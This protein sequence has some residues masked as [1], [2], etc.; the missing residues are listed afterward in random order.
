[1][2]R[3]VFHLCLA[4]V[5]ML[6]LLPLSAA[7]TTEQRWKRAID[8]DD[9][10][11]I[12]QM[13]SGTD[14]TLTNDK[15]KT[16]LMTA[17]KLGDQQLLQIL[18]DKGLTLEDRSFT[19]GTA[20]MYAALGNQLEMLRFLQQQVPGSAYRDAQSTN[21]W[22][23]I[24]IAAAKG[25]DSTVK[26]LVEGGANPWLADAYQWS[27]LMR[28]IDNRHTRVVNY[29]ISLP[30]AP[31]DHQNENGSTALHIAVLKGDESAVRR[32]LKAGAGTELKD[33]NLMAAV[34]IAIA[35]GS[36]DILKLLKRQDP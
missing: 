14:I 22:T 27:P 33:K 10:S 12:W 18:L 20:L 17:A 23:A 13:L 28:A 24:M 2:V 1:M 15:G 21:G 26:I 36:V 32:L 16:A 29:L 34:D 31:L 6:V 5:L 4:V 7:E 30:D 25:F 35:N 8:R 9:S 19:G 3:R 11:V